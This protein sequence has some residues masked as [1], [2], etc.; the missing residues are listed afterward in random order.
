MAMALM[1]GPINAAAIDSGAAAAGE[2]LTADGAGGAAWQAVSAPAPEPALRMRTTGTSLS[3][4]LKW[5][6]GMTLDG[7]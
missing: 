6:G 1:L 5:G 2:V 7:L 3:L 4:T